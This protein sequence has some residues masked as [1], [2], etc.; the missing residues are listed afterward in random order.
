M[1]RNRTLLLVRVASGGV[2]IA[3]GAG[4][5]VNHASGSAGLNAPSG[6]RA[7]SPP[8]A[9]RFVYSPAELQ[10]GGS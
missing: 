4:K 3:F 2:F 6:W 1:K 5:F 7:V 8:A 9:A 10:S